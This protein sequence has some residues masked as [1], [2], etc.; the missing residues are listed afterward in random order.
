M[1]SWL[2]RRTQIEATRGADAWNV[3]KPSCRRTT[4]RRLGNRLPDQQRTVQVPHRGYAGTLASRTER[5]RRRR[6]SPYVCV[7]A[8]SS[9]QRS[10]APCTFIQNCG[11]VS[12]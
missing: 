2:N 12:K 9:F 4:R 3:T 10:H 6:I 8:C 1:S 11:L 7:P 5:G